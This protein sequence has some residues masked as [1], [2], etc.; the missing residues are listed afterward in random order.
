M[1][2]HSYEINRYIQTNKDDIIA[3]RDK[4]FTLSDIANKYGVS[5]GAIYN[6]LY[7]WKFFAEYEKSEWLKAKQEE[8]TKINDEYIEYVEFTHSTEDQRLV[9]NLLKLPIIG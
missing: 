2:R 6:N 8:N 7:K 4:G 9:D 1:N 5:I 3:M